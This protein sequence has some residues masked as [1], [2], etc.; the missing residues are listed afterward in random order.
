MRNAGKYQPIFL[1]GDRPTATLVGSPKFFTGAPK[2]ADFLWE[3][4]SRTGELR[5]GVMEADSQT[6]VRLA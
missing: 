3:A 4:R 1:T 2:M 5:K 6:A